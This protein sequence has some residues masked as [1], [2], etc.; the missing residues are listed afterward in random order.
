VD[1]ELHR[2][3]RA[4]APF[5]I[6]D[7][8]LAQF[9]ELT[10]QARGLMLYLLSLPDD[11]KISIN[12]LASSTDKSRQPAKRKAVYAMLDELIEHG[13]I[14]RTRIQGDDG[15]VVK[16]VYRVFDHPLSP[17]GEVAQGL[18][19]QERL[20]SNS[21]TQRKKLDKDA[22][23]KAGAKCTFDEFCKAC[24]DAGEQ[25]VPADDPVFEDMRTAGIPS[26]Y[27]VLHWAWF[28]QWA[29]ELD[30]T[31]KERRYA[32]IRGW[33]QVF[34][35]SMRGGWSKLWWKDNKSGQWC[36]TQAGIMAQAAKTNGRE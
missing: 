28:R 9:G 8:G 7:R 23:A 32:G 36:L 18:V 19:A 16:W 1:I 29:V 13:Y 20:Q 15:R 14:S 35:K 26:S 2:Q 3:R 12:H 17:E 33:R 5:V 31:G 4:D 22:P 21:N 30:A 10:W 25:K 34:R 6:I 11:W 27:L 24:E